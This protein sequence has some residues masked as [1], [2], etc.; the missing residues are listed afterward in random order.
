[1]FS[2]SP[3]CET[4]AYLIAAR[5]LWILWLLLTALLDQRV[6][7]ELSPGKS[8]IL[9]PITGTSTELGSL[10]TGFVKMCL[11]TLLKQPHMYF[12]FVSTG[13]CSPASFTPKVT[14]NELA[15]Y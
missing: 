7:T 5:L 10:A 8:T 1:M 3:N 11:L 14:P 4:S 13:I 15:A 12:L 2:P 9:Q 6:I